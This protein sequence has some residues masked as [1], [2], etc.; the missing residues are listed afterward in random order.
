MAWDVDAL[1]SITAISPA[2]EQNLPRKWPSMVKYSTHTA[3]GISLA[4]SSNAGKRPEWRFEFEN[5][6]S[7]HRQDDCCEQ[8][9]AR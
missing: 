1:T 2:A 7:L 9:S 4:M 8:Y 5:F 6:G 3:A